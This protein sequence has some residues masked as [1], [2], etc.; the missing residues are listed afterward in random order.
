[1]I[2]KRYVVNG[3]MVEP[4]QE[5]CANLERRLVADLDVLRQGGLDCKSPGLYL[6]RHRSL[7]AGY[8][9][10]TR[11]ACERHFLSLGVCEALTPAGR[12][13]FDNPLLWEVVVFLK[14][15]RLFVEVFAKSPADLPFKDPP[16]GVMKEIDDDAFTFLSGDQALAFP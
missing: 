7:V 14:G 3:K 13:D 10:A 5:E 15:T 11:E 12:P 6:E 2:F 16:E 1:M 4:C 8:A 9:E